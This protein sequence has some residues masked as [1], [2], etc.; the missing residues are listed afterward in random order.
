MSET[1]FSDIFDAMSKG[2]LEHYGVKG[3]KWGVRRTPAQLGHKTSTKRK[4][5]GVFSK[6][7]KG[8]K[9]KVQKNVTQKKEESKEEIRAKLLKSTDP[10]YISKHI[11]LL[12]TRELQERIDRINKEATMKKLAASKDKDKVKKGED[13][14]KTISNVME[15]VS[16]ISD[17]YSKIS[18][19]A[20]KTKKQSGDDKSKKADD[21]K[22]AAI[23]KAL[24]DLNKYGIMENISPD[25][26]LKSINT[27][28]KAYDAVKD[29]ND[30]EISFNARTG[31]PVFKKKRT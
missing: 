14:L 10:K 22:K 6:L 15:S 8:T 5:P 29:L 9:K 21:A 17:S 4:K 27:A 3:M 1:D 19:N 13:A 26:L 7:A 20:N 18:D 24:R 2:Y 30:I 11:D 31:E 16:K 12:D 25:D 28:S 23:D